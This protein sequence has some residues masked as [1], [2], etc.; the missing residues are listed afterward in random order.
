MSVVVDY[1]LSSGCKR[2]VLN[3]TGIFMLYSQKGLAYNE[4]VTN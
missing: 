4:R 1:V 3:E 2:F